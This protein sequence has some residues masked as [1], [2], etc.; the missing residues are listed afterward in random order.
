[1]RQ[2]FSILRAATRWCLQYPLGRSQWLSLGAWLVLLALGMLA[3]GQYVAF[4]T[5]RDADL[6]DQGAY[7]MLAEKNRDWWPSATE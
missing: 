4:S 3:L 5:N 7:L 1:M 2:V 6:Y